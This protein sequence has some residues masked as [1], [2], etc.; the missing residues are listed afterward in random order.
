MGRETS[1]STCIRK[2][3]VSTSHPEYRK[4]KFLPES[5]IDEILS[6]ERVR[7]TIAKC[8]KHEN[9]S[10][11]R[12]FRN[13]TANIEGDVE[14]I[15]NPQNINQDE[16]SMVKSY[17]KIFIILFLVQKASFITWFIDKGICDDDLPLRLKSET[18][19]KWPPVRRGGEPLPMEAL[20]EGF[21]EKFIEKQWFVLAPCFRPSDEGAKDEPQELSEE[22][23]PPFTSWRPIGKGGFGEVVEVRIHAG[24]HRFNDISVCSFHSALFLSLSPAIDS[25]DYRIRGCLL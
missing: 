19:M 11:V 24:Q 23:I 13:S 7:K 25:L 14:T 21:F 9:Y 8:R 10:Q 15:C 18:G 17:R 4:A 1:L 12:R 2:A 22:H 3:S 20:S 6:V 16:H 5:D